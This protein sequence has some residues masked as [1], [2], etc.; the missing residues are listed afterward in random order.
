LVGGSRGNGEKFGWGKVLLRDVSW[1]TYDRLIEER[2]E[3]R[4]PRFHY[5]R[6]V[7][8]IVSPSSMYEGISRIVASLVDIM[9]EEINL[10]VFGAGS[11]TFKREDP[12]RGFEP[13]ECFYF[14]DNAERVRGKEGMDLG[15]GDPPPDLVVE[16]DVTSPSLDKP[17]IYAHLGVAEV[18]RFSGGGA[19][20]LVLRGGAYETA[21]ASLAIP[22]LARDSLARFVERGLTIKRP[23]W[24]REVRE[25]IGRWK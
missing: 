25:E 20:I 15:A 21:E 5:D 6:G 13:D 1:R 23:A 2:R 9:T 10:D 19:E 22:F 7:M 18:W 17:G 16:V 3:R 11:T 8:E 14:S 12:G 24:A 4:T